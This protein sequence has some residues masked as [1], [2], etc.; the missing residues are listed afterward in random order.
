MIDKI[1]LINTIA[2]K[3]GH[4]LG[5]EKSQTREDIERNIRALVSHALARLDVVNREEFDA[6][7]AVLH[8]TRQRLEALEKQLAQLH[9][10]DVRQDLSTPQDSPDRA[11]HQDG[12][13]DD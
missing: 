4:L 3:A 7:V 10:M 2:E 13:D 9:A 11:G 12:T 1:A 6:Q 5:G 8:H